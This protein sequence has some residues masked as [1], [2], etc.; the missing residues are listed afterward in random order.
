MMNELGNID[1]LENLMRSASNPGALAE[2]D[3]DVAKRL[4]G[5]DAARSLEKLADLAKML[6]KA[7]LIENKEGRYELTPK[8]L[9]KIGANALNDLFTP[10]RC[11]RADAGPTCLSPVW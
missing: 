7:G 10:R 11:A 8:G 6:E 3:I 9:R 2:A 1:Q 4:L 5:D